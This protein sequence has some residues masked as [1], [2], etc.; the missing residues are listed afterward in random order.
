MF[1]FDFLF[2]YYFFNFKNYIQ[3]IY[4]F[5]EENVLTHPKE[6]SVRDAVWRAY[7]DISFTYFK[8][9]MRGLSNFKSVF[10]AESII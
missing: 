7:N 2:Y 4:K 3:T 1:K 10:N 5:N 8:V 6:K 9:H